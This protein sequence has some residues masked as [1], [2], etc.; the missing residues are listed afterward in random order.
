M[1]REITDEEIMEWTQSLTEQEQQELFEG[2]NMRAA[3]L[4]HKL[5]PNS[6]VIWD[7]V[8]DKTYRQ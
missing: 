7:M 8:L 3:L 1:A 5:F 2:I 6:K 4:M